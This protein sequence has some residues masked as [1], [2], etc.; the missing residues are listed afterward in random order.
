VRFIEIIDLIAVVRRRS[1]RNPSLSSFRSRFGGFKPIKLSSKRAKALIGIA[2]VVPAIAIPATASATTVNL[3]GSGSSAAQSY[4]Q[5]LFAAYHQ[6]HKN[7]VFHYNP[8]GGNAGVTDVADGSSEFAIQ[9]AAP[10]K[11]AVPTTWAKLFLDGLCIDVNSSNNLSN[12]T[13]AQ[14]ADIFQSNPLDTVWNQVSSGDSLGTQTILPEGRNSAAGQYT[15]FVA[16]ILHGGSENSAVTQESTDGEVKVQIETHK[17][18]IGYVGLANSV[19]KGEKALSLNGVACTA[20][21]IGKETYP[22]WRWDWV[23]LPKSNPNPNL[24]PF[25]NWVTNSPAAVKIIN[26]AGAVARRHPLL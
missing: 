19:G 24:I 18:A 22:L 1:E 5:A 21:N 4:M 23:V 7:I 2:A 9:T 8:D 6:L 14:V 10:S 26:S 15:F 25:F 13:E 17:N 16:S 12:A 11:T 20:T 3:Y